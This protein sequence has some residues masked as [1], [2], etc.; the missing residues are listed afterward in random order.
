MRLSSIYWPVVSPVA[1][2]SVRF[3]TCDLSAPRKANGTGK[4]LRNKWYVYWIRDLSKTA[5][6]FKMEASLGG[7]WERLFE[8]SSVPAFTRGTWSHTLVCGMSES[9]Q[10]NGCGIC[11]LHLS[12][13]CVSCHIQL[14]LSGNQRDTE[15]WRLLNQP[16][17][18][19]IKTCVQ[20]ELSFLSSSMWHFHNLFVG[21]SIFQAFIFF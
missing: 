1:V 16:G 12:N 9:T 3:L 19:H 17:N 5:G 15:N 2:L 13:W 18:H 4:L 10:T 7:R 8:L 6:R 20:M 11:H 14:M 21:F